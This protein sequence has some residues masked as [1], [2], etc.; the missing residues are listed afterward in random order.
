MYNVNSA[1]KE[2][3]EPKNAAMFPNLEKVFPESGFDRMHEKN[4]SSD[5]LKNKYG[6]FDHAL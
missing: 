5:E 6:K 1:R 2:K 4:T 3:N